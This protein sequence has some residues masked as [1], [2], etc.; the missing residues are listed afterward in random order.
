MLPAEELARLRVERAVAKANYHR[1]VCNRIEGN[2][3]VFRRTS[4]PSMMSIIS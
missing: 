2:P 4:G 3:K 1:T